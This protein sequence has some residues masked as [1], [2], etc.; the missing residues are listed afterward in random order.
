MPVDEV[1]TADLMR[2]LV[3]LWRRQRPTGQR[4]RQR[5]SRAERRREVMEAWSAFLIG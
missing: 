4:L 5:G 2:V 1:Q 3:P